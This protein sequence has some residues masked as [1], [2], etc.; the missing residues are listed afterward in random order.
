M[1]YLD[2]NKMNILPK[3]YKEF[4]SKDY[5]DKFFRELKK[6]GNQENF[7]WYGNY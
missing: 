3:N 4:L 6:K 5:W 7:E 1:Q 2:N